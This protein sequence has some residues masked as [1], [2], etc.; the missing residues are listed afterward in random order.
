MYGTIRE[1]TPENGS[2][3]GAGNR[4]RHRLNWVLPKNARNTRRRTKM[5]QPELDLGLPPASQLL[6]R[7]SDVILCCPSCGMYWFP[8]KNKPKSGE[9]VDGR[10]VAIKPCPG[11][12]QECHPHFL[13]G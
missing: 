5:K 2:A 8:V 7:M 13:H 1:K 4:C 9:T 3:G 10:V 11:C 6:E 12:V